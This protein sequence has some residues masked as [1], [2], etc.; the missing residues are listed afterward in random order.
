[1]PGTQINYDSIGSNSKWLTGRNEISPLRDAALRRLTESEI[2]LLKSQR[3]Y[4][5]DWG[6]ILISD[7]TNL[8]LIRNNS[9]YGL[10]RIDAL[11]PAQLEHHDL[12]LPIGI[13]HSTIVNTDIGANCCIHHVRYMAQMVISPQCILHNIG[14]IITSAHAKFGNGIIAPGEEE[15]KRIWIEFVNENGGRRGL[16]FQHITLSDAVIWSSTKGDDGLQQKLQMFTQNQASQEK[17]LFGQVGKHSVIKNCKALKDVRIGDYAY[18]KGANKLKNITVLSDEESP[19]QIGEGVEMVNGIMGYGSRC[20][21]GVKAVRFIMG[22]NTTLKYGARLL[23]S[24]LGDNST[25]SCCE[26]LNSLIFP[27]HEQHHNNSFLCAAQVEGQ[28]NIASGATLGSNHNSRKS[29]GE[30]FAK[31]GF[32]PGLCVSLRHNSRFASF[33][34]I[35]KGD[36]PNELDIPFPFSLIINKADQDELWI[37]PAYWLLY[38]QYSLYR[39]QLKFKN[40]DRRKKNLQAIQTNFLA[41]DTASEIYNALKL[42]KQIDQQ[43]AHLLNKNIFAVENSNRKVRILK[44]NL[45]IAAYE[46]ALKLYCL[47]I[48]LNNTARYQSAIPK[49]IDWVNFGGRLVPQKEVSNLYK[50][51]NENK[52]N[53]WTAIH[54]V[55]ETMDIKY[56]AHQLAHAKWLSEANGW[57]WTE[58]K[59]DQLIEIYS[60]LVKDAMEKVQSSRRKDFENAFRKMVYT[61]PDEMAAVL[62]TFD[63][64]AVVQ[65]ILLYLKE[66]KSKALS[67]LDFS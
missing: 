51:I 59:S 55:Y 39:N 52:Y 19:S 37:M 24:F 32:W 61:S 49:S 63:S 67:T 23:N 29:D 60:H 54:E 13:Y 62:G 56:Q 2:E 48:Y 57:Y 66:K 40:R 27:F 20:F 47:E 16:P 30:L 17:Y 9:L 6:Q 41:P 53:S 5:P 44:L 18:I 38:N 42:L 1:M 34:M 10:I 50:G 33:S 15:A 28:S 46:A 36:F 26:V 12:V 4:C 3:N 8:G 64:E 43:S 14:E 58:I 11:E 25:I 65:E 22:E 7:A 35:A 45:A 21:Y 31:R